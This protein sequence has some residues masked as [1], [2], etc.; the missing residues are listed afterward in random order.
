MLKVFRENLKY[1]NWILWLVIAIFVAF[2]FVD[3]GI[4]GLDNQQGASYAAKV[5]SSTV[6]MQEFERTYRQLE[7]QYRDIYGERFTPEVAKQMQLP[8]QALDRLVAR[9]I[10]L[11]EAQDM[12]LTASDEEVRGRSWISKA[13]RPPT[14]PSWATRNTPPSC[15]R[16]DRAPP[17]RAQ[18]A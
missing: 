12:D 14:A 13:S 9:Q 18:R 2:I 17:L 11:A 15:A 10:L 8:M 4:G 3:W 7:A 1:L 6:S 16:T 5:G